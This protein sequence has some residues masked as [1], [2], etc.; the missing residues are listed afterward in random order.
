MRH[1]INVRSE[2]GSNSPLILYNLWSETVGWQ[3][4]WFLLEAAPPRFSSNPSLAGGPSARRKEQP[5]DDRA[6]T[7]FNQRLNRFPLRDRDLQPEG[8]EDRDLRR[9]P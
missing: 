1:A 6:S 8:C 5:T 3:P 9:I 2:P 4:M 7:R